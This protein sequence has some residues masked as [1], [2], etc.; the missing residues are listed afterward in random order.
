MGNLNLTP[1]KNI[2]LKGKPF[3]HCVLKWNKPGNF[4]WKHLD[5][6]DI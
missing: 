1:D 2:T 4:L 6:P 5:I 3:T